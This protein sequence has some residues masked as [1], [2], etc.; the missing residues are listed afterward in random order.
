MKTSTPVPRKGLTIVQLLTKRIKQLLE[1]LEMAF[2]SQ[3]NQG[4]DEDELG[5]LDDRAEIQLDALGRLD[6]VEHVVVKIARIKR[7]SRR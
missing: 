2:D 7:S 1:I 4:K 5:E 6:L 3:V